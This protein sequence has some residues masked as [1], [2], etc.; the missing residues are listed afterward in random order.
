MNARMDLFTCYSIRILSFIDP[1]SFM[2]KGECDEIN[3]S[4]MEEFCQSCCSRWRSLPSYLGLENSVVEDIE[5]QYRTEVDRRN[6]F[7]CRWKHRKG[8]EAKYK[9]LIEALVNIGCTDDA[10]K[11]CEI[12]QKQIIDPEKIKKSKLINSLGS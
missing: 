9:N 3:T 6:G 1:P 10:R 12:L 5:S 8:C 4:D 11:L 7:L 2:N